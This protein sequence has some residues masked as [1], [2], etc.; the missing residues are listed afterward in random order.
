MK[1]SVS[2]FSANS[3]CTALVLKQVN[4]TPHRFSV[5]RLTVTSRGPKESTPVCRNGRLYECVLNV[6]SGAMRGALEAAVFKMH[7][8]SNFSHFLKLFV[9]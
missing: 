3:R 4:I 2:S 5:E 1:V 9:D 6:G 7:L 8:G